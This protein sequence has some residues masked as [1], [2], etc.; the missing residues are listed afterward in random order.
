MATTKPRITITLTQRQHDVLKVIS[1]SSG[2]PMSAF[3]SEMMETT[4]PTLERMAVTFQKMKQAKDMQRSRWVGALDDAQAALEP[5]AMAAVGQFDLFM[6]KLD[7]AIEDERDAPRGARAQPQEPPPAPSTNRGATPRKAKTAKPTAAS[8]SKVS[9][10][11]E[12]SKQRRMP[13]A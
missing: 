6:G 2:Q 9:K 8:V 5:I 13:T 11:K 4:L 1:E 12:N 7:A 10:V 3:I